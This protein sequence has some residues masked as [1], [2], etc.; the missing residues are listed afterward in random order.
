M[1]ARRERH[2]SRQLGRGRDM[3]CQH[4]KIPS[5]HLGSLWEGSVV[6]SEKIPPFFG[7]TPRP[8]EKG[9]IRNTTQSRSSRDSEFIDTEK[10]DLFHSMGRKAKPTGEVTE[11]ALAP[12]K[13]LFQ[14]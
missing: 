2:S 11:V 6:L 3:R 5:L 12:E 13:S 14:L 9:T 4:L 7:K 8:P 10:D 1:R